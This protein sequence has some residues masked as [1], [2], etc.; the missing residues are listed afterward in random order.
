MRDPDQAGLPVAPLIPTD[1]KV[2]QS[3]KAVITQF[4]LDTNAANSIGGI[5]DRTLTRFNALSLTYDV[6]LLISRL[7]DIYTVDPN[8]LIFNP[9][10][11]E[12]LSPL[13]QNEV[14]YPQTW[15]ELIPIPFEPPPFELTPVPIKL[16]IQDM[17]FI[18][19]TKTNDGHSDITFK[20]DL[21]KIQPPLE[22]PF[23]QFPEIEIGSPLLLPSRPGQNSPRFNPWLPKPD[24]LIPG[25]R[26][27][28]NLPEV[29]PDYDF[30]NI[31]KL[32]FSVRTGTEAQPGI[33]FKIRKALDPDKVK[34]EENKLRKD[35]KRQS[36]KAYMFTMNMVSKTFG[37]VTEIA[38]FYNALIW[39]IWIK[40]TKPMTIQ[41]DSIDGSGTYD[42][43]LMNAQRVGSL[44][45]NAQKEILLMIARGDKSLAY[46]VNY[47]GLQRDVMMQ[48]LSDHSAAGKAKLERRFSNDMSGISILDFGNLSTWF[49]RIER[50]YNN[51]E[52]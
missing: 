31:P 20:F 34:W 5:V 25:W 50:T 17:P 11:L 21:N 22:L 4:G 3:I 8:E 49:N 1:P 28:P 15:P 51:E 44:P 14:W 33:E 41:V 42:I 46:S 29:L 13:Q 36:A 45:V 35:D 32:S 43:F 39:N 6:G 10:I 24:I 27:Y 48:Q 18:M 38:D 16:P 23:I 37:R 12:E 2:K 40:P 26:T 30:P 9:E 47:E 7:W 52:N 19:D